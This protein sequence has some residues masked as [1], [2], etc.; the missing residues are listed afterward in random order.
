MFIKSKP[1]ILPPP[2]FNRRSD[3]D[4]KRQ[5]FFESGSDA[6]CYTIKHSSLLQSQKILLPSYCC[7]DVVKKLEGSGYAVQYIDPRIDLVIDEFELHRIIE[8]YNIGVYIHINYFGVTGMPSEK[9]ISFLRDKKVELIVDCCHTYCNLDAIL[10]F[11]LNC[12][13]IFSL[14]KISPVPDGGLLVSCG[15]DLDD[16]VHFKK[17]NF[18]KLNIIFIIK[19]ILLSTKILQANFVKIAGHFFL[20]FVENLQDYLIRPFNKKKLNLVA[21]L[22]RPSVFVEYLL[23]NK[24]HMNMIVSLRNSNFKR[25]KMCCSQLG[26]STIGNQSIAGVGLWCAQ[27]LPILDH[28]KTLLPFLRKNHIYAYNWPY[29]NL[30]DEVFRNDKLPVANLLME[31]IVC[32][33]IHQDLTPLC[34]GYVENVIKEWRESFG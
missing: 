24:T 2:F 6:I 9:T 22:S 18:F 7:K 8:N 29:L 31:V 33:P 34:L 19:E 4:A 32:V 23:K 15:Y 17:V 30:P 12:T 25:L 1:W 26:I 21:P 20:T 3:F 14:R 16:N 13:F 27:V 10:K 11:G 5:F 28:T